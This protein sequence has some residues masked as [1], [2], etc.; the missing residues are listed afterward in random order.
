MRCQY[1]CCTL[2]STFTVHYICFV[3]FFPEQ[4]WES[5]ML[6][7]LRNPEVNTKKRMNC[8][9]WTLLRW[10][11]FT[12][13]LCC[14]RIHIVLFFI[15]LFHFHSTQPTVLPLPMMMTTSRRRR[16]RREETIAGDSATSFLLVNTLRRAL[17]MMTCS[18]IPKRMV[19]VYFVP[20]TTIG[21]TAIDLLWFAYL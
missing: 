11:R 17:G 13:A 12:H 15:C 10:W 14:D 19:A 18:G 6:S 3:L 2:L 16:R 7:C 1:L 9:T 8:S 21:I 4:V 20:L 5:V